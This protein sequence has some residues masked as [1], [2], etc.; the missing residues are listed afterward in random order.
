MT[1]AVA[2]EVEE[3]LETAEAAYN[4][5]LA[6]WVA[7]IKEDLVKLRKGELKTYSPEEYEPIRQEMRRRLIEK[8]A[9]QSHQPL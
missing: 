4:A 8:Y 3:Y 6:R 5:A 1:T 9:N 7:G 2:V